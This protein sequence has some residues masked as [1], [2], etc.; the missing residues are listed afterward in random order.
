MSS[1]QKRCTFDGLYSHMPIPDSIL[2]N[3]PCNVSTLVA[4][5]GSAFAIQCFQHSFKT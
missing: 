1:L 5:N 4:V 3:S 2:L